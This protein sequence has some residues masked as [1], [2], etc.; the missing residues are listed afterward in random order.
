MGVSV[1]YR[2][3]SNSSNNVCYKPKNPKFVQN[4]TAKGVMRSFS[5]YITHIKPLENGDYES[6]L[7]RPPSTSNNVCYKLKNQKIC[8]G[9]HNKRGYVVVFHVY[10]TNQTL[11]KRGLWKCT[12]TPPSTSNNAC[13]KAKIPKIC[14]EPQSKRGYVVVF[15]VIYITQIKPLENGDYEIL[16]KHP[17]QPQ[18]MRVTRQKTL[19]SARNHTAKRVM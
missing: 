8:S 13:Y 10:H 4:H 7:K 16:L 19:K 5:M 15:H 6:V 14:S 17:L 3:S 9:P 1:S 18:I 11:G 2:S 12:K